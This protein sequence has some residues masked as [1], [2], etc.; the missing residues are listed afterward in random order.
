[1]VEAVCTALGRWC[2]TVEAE[3]QPSTLR[4]PGLAHLATP[5]R[6]RLS[7]GA[8]VY[9][10]LE[11]LHPTPAVG[12]VPRSA[13]MAWIRTHERYARGWYTGGFGWV[14]DGDRAELAVVLRC[15][16]LRGT[17]LTLHAGAGITRISRPGNELAETELK[18]RTL[19]DRLLS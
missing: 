11:A 4:L 18:L 16:L 14:G 3:T 19:R 15:G 10:L 9:G 13:A 17:E 5:V 6:G 2:D 12:G 8:D 1:V 7:P